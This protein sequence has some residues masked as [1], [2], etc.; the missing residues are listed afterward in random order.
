MKQDALSFIL[1][2]SF[3]F[4]K[5]FYF[6]SGNEKTL[7]DKVKKKIIENYQKSENI[8]VEDIDTID[9]F[10]SNGSL[11]TERK[12]CFVKGIKSLDENGIDKLRNLDCIFIFVQENSQKIKKI[13]SLFAKDK[14]AYL[15][16]CYELD[17]NTKSKILNEFFK[18]SQIKV[19]QDIYWFLVE[20]LDNKYGLLEDSLNKISKLNQ[21]DITLKNIKKILTISDSGKDKFFFILL[22]KNKEIIENY[23][24][25]IVNSTDVNDLY[26]HCKF[27]CQLIIESKNEDEYNKKIPLYLFK[28]RG[29]LIDLY[30]RYNIKKKRLLL[31][32]LSSTEK[33]LRKESGLSLISGLRFILNIKKITIS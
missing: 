20:K 22:N 30:R 10:N 28:E 7:I 33:M 29:F 5:K 26:Y 13:K 9:D 4:N 3:E 16:D 6:I 18:H 1:D 2:K 11:F 21:N 32:L 19:E 15:I 12:V 17:K 24:E 25:K 27:F 8:F 23:R 14:Q 31:S